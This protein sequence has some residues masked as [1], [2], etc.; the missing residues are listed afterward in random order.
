MY[1]VIQVPMPIVMY[2]PPMN[3]ADSARGASRL[4]NAI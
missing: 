2:H 3:T 4:V 1:P